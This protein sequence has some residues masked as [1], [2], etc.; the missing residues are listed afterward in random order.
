MIALD[1]AFDAS[2]VVALAAELAIVCTASTGTIKNNPNS[3]RAVA[4]H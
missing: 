1:V 2:Q 3:Y 4:F